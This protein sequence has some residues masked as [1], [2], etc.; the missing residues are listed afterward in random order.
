MVNTSSSKF[1]VSKAVLNNESP[2][3]VLHLGG[4]VGQN[5]TSMLKDSVCGG[6]QQP[7][8]QAKK[9]TTG[10]LLEEKHLWI[11]K[12]VSMKFMV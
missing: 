6:L 2:R 1:I 5:H 4:V 10:K 8:R 7:A 9:L 12:M 11:G 3:H